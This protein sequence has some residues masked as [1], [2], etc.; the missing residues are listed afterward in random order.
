MIDR[1]YGT[2]AGGFGDDEPSPV[3]AE[4]IC[5]SWA[6]GRADLT[7]EWTVGSSDPG[8]CGPGG[9][10]IS[11]EFGDDGSSPVRGKKYD[12]FNILYCN[13]F[14]MINLF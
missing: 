9:Q 1:N 8:V 14:D 11:G 10:V 2:T 4:N 3:P 13:V 5:V 12:L 7:L 6:H